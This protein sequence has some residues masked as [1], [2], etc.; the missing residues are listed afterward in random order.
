MTKKTKSLSKAALAKR[1]VAY[2]LAAGAAAFSTTV[3]HDADAA[4]VYSGL[5]NIDNVASVDPPFPDPYRLF[6]D[7]DNDTFS[8]VALQNAIFGGSPYQGV[9]VLGDGQVVG[10]NAG[11]NNYAYVS[12]LTEGAVIDGTTVGPSFFGSMAFGGQNPNAEFN[13][14][15]D[16]YIGLSFGSS[17]NLRFGWV[18]VGIDNS[19]ASFVVKDWA[20]ES[21]VGVG[22]NAGQVPE[23]G[24]LGMLA[25]GA[26]GVAAM[27]RRRK[28]MA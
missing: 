16:A 10:F 15:P 25:A 8:D 24:A 1:K 23:P 12:N 3:D 22:I 14:A 4:P 19:S 27:R 28:Q 13:N 5:Q 18:R 2:S 11:A 6:L 17:P 21:E 26:A 9:S 7:L 20:Y